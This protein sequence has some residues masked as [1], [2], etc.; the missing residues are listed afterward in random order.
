MANEESNSKKKRRIAS[1]SLLL[2]LCILT[3]HVMMRAADAHYSFS[4]SK[5]TPPSDNCRM[6]WMWPNF[7]KVDIKSTS[8]YALYTYCEHACSPA[9][10]LDAIP[11][12]FIPGNAGS[13]Q[14][15]RSIASV[16]ITEAKSKSI[17][18]VIY[19]VD[20]KEELSAFSGRT[21][22]EQSRFA[23]FAIK[24]I[25]S[26]HRSKSV[27]LIGHSMG[28]IVSRVLFILPNFIPNS[29][30]TII[31]FAT[32]HKSPPLAIDPLL[33]SLY[34]KINKPWKN[35]SRMNN[36]SI[37]SISGGSLDKL[38]EST[39][40][41]V[42]HF[43]GYAGGFSVLSSSIPKVWSEA[44]HL[45]IVWCHQLLTSVA[46]SLVA[47]DFENS[48][49]DLK[50]NWFRKNFV[51]GVVDILE[52]AKNESQDELNSQMSQTFHLNGKFYSLS[53]NLIPGLHTLIRPKS[54]VNPQ[55]TLI[56]K[57]QNIQKQLKFYSCE[58]TNENNVQSIKFPTCITLASNLRLIPGGPMVK[59]A[60]PGELRYD[61]P[62]LW[63]LDVNANEIGG[64]ATSEVVLEIS[65][66]EKDMWIFVE[67]RDLLGVSGVLNPIYFPHF[68]WNKTPQ[69]ISS[70][71]L[72]T[73]MELP[74]I[75]NSFYK[76]I[77]NPKP[78]LS[79]FFIF[80]L[81]ST[82]NTP[83]TIHILNNPTECTEIKL[84][85]HFDFYATLSLL[86][87]RNQTRWLSHMVF[88]I[89]MTLSF[90]LGYTKPMLTPPSPP[91]AEDKADLYFREIEILVGST[92]FL[93]SFPGALQ[94]VFLREPQPWFNDIREKHVTVWFCWVVVVPLFVLEYLRGGG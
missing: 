54:V 7:R 70:N 94:R 8:K 10:N 51:E 2:G 67:W 15:V 38:V 61:D 63:Y 48:D 83:S 87:S 93:Y 33:V 59:T 62:V 58:I 90:Q 12:L 81:S 57:S 20:F 73:V 34:S 37:V 65:N 3:A 6:T 40:T 26:Q 18:F 13:Y 86:I 80:P 43:V 49:R 25:L 85:T 66:L 46:R 29:V 28:G 30:I 82:S 36:V 56:A 23:N 1:L 55:L 77:V 4:T 11:V 17:H 32:P 75:D 22:I 52:L 24:E 31:T 42:D 60:K 9:V 21:I 45:Q 16:L 71:S 91:T 69:I 92:R 78:D 79:Q 47:M 89:L 76:F 35:S 44:D 50:V 88:A 19:A 53:S 5:N 68:S 39:L 84:T 14:Q 41:N 27:I 64:N 72:M 74:Y